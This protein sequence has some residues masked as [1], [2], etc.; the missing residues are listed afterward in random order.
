MS[1]RG[2][3]TLYLRP[4]SDIIRDNKYNVAVLDKV[5]VIYLKI[6]KCFTSSDMYIPNKNLLLTFYDLYYALC[7]REVATSFEPAERFFF[8]TDT[9]E[10][11]YLT[12][13]R[14]CMIRNRI[15]ITFKISHRVLNIFQKMHL[16]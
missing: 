8:T 3:S 4:R 14:H 12:D 13:K 5:N 16:E 6:V 2:D 11:N 9:S 10:C 7:C 15:L 1:R